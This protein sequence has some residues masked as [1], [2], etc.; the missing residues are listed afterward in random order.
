MNSVSPVHKI[1]KS[2]F[3]FIGKSIKTS[4][5]FQEHQPGGS[6]VIFE[7]DVELAMRGGGG[8]GAIEAVLLWNNDDM[9]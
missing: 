1:R 2:H 9:W 4:F 3:I 6:T 5:N 8:G 7:A